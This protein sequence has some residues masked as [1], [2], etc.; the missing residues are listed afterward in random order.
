MKRLLLI[1]AVCL[2]LSS[3]GFGQ[4]GSLTKVLDKAKS[5]SDM[6]ITDEDERALGQAISE[7]TASAN[8]GT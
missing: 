4:F 3:F 1:S 7:L 5:I 8:S 2:I 6:Q